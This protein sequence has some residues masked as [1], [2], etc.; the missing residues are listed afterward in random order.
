MTANDIK[1]QLIA[2]G[3]AEKAAHSLYFFKTEKGQYGEGDRFVGV[4]APEVKSIVKKFKELPID[5]IE[6][7]LS[8]E[9]HEC[10][11]CALLI[12]V[13]RFKRADEATRSGIV[14]FYLAHSQ[15]INNWDL[16]D[17]SSYVIL[18]EWLLDKDR[19]IL[20][21]LSKSNSLWEQRIA[22]VSTM[23]F[24][25]QN[26]FKDALL[27]SKIYLTHKHDL[28]HKAS[29]WMLREVGKRDEGVLTGFLDIHHKQMPRTMLRYSIEKLSPEQKKHYMTK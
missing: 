27:L 20:Y 22:M 9:I 1:N 19:S 8:D 26:D 15:Y 18:G 13:E 6:L 29:G 12:L 2:F 16:V 14:D 5:E 11:L 7:L 23:T 28:I 24:I 4:T 25:R 3:N 17:I 10:R 21:D